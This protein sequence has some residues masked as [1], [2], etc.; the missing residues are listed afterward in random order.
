MSLIYPETQHDDHR[1][2]TSKAERYGWDKVE[3][4]PGRFDYIDKLSLAI[5]PSV[6]RD[7]ETKESQ[8]RILKM[9]AGWDWISCGALSVSLRGGK[10]VVFDGQHRL[11]AAMKRE[12]IK[13]LPCLVFKNTTVAD[14]A[15]GFLKINVAKRPVGV[16]DRH[17]IAIM[18]QD[19]TATAV[20]RLV[21]ASGIVMARTPTA[22]QTK[23]IDWINKNVAQPHIQH[24]LCVSVDVI[25]DVPISRRILEAL[26]YLHRFTQTG[27]DDRL[28]GIL[29]QRGGEALERGMTRAAAGFAR[30]GAKV[31]AA[32]ILD[33][34]NHGLKNRIELLNEAV[35]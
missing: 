24:V 33:V 14:E 20:E 2:A 7:A 32:G 11:L 31:F 35:R 1:C 17:R 28:V 10:Y 8:A 27:L 34:V 30:G 23:S 3:N 4:Q 19:E 21:R 12:E 25:R 13:V 18:A 6:Q 5:D 9:A 22:G 16:F 15:A 29:R 26:T